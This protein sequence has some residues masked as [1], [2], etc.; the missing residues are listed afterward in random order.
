MIFAELRVVPVGKLFEKIRSG[1]Q[2]GSGQG[3]SAECPLL[4][5]NSGRHLLNSSSSGF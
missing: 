2:V 5:V 1:R 3:S 4:K